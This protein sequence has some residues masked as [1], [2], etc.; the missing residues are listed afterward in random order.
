MRPRWN[1]S[2]AVRG[3]RRGFTLVEI[4]AVLAVVLILALAMLAAGVRHLDFLSAQAE[5]AALKTISAALQS[6]ILQARYIP[7]QNSWYS[8]VATNAGM[9]TNDVLYTPRNIRRVYLIDPSFLVGTGSGQPL[10]YSQTITGS[11]F[12]PVNARVM[13]LSSMGTALPVT[14]GTNSAFNTIWNTPDGLVPNDLAWSSFKNGSDLKIQRLNLQALF[15]QVIINPSAYNTTGG[16]SIDTSITNK[17]PAAGSGAFSGYY[18]HGTVLGLYWTN[19]PVISQMIAR[20]CSFTFDN[21]GWHG[22]LLNLN[23]STNSQIASANLMYD[24][25]VQLFLSSPSN[26]YNGETP[27]QVFSAYTNYLT[28]YYTWATNGFTN[29]AFSTAVANAAIAVD[30]ADSAAA[31]PK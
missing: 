7:D 14:S 31:S 27:M 26:I 19:V 10:P 5:T 16:F 18:L 25:I 22:S 8:C 11:A 1:S 4:V 29:L 23:S 21:A 28:A 30:A 17:P 12:N 24:T 9:H 3:G 2:L 15:H 20:D 6:S 13:I